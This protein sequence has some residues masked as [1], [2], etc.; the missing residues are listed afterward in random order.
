MMIRLWTAERHGRI[1]N[2]DRERNDENDGRISII[3]ELR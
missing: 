2:A 3:L 1:L